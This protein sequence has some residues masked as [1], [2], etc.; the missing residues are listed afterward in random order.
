MKNIPI[1]VMLVISQVL[2][3]IWLSRGMKTIGQVSSLTPIAVGR[4]VLDLLANPWI[5]LGVCTLIFALLLY[6]TAIS[7]LDLSYVL[8][9]RASGYVFNAILASFLLGE[10]ICGTRWLATLIIASGVLIVSWSEQ[11]QIQATI[12]SPKKASKRKIQKNPINFSWIV[13]PGF[14]ISNLWLGI[15]VMVMGDS[16]GDIFMAKGMKKIGKVGLAPVPQMLKLLGRIITSPLILTGIVCYAISFSTFLSLLSWADISL[17]RPVTA[18]GYMVSLLGAK[19]FL[20]EKITPG[21]L[22]GVIVITIGVGVI[23]VT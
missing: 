19:Y 1:L 4:S 3:D 15:L 14:Y 22:L 18:I 2:G 20:Q 9:I 13:L 7:R 6:L 23:S 8:P 12:Q 11:R 10:E 17:I 21:R 16:A 5:W